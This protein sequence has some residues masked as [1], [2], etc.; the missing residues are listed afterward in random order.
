[1]TLEQ[2]TIRNV[3][4]SWAITYQGLTHRTLAF[5]VPVDVL[6][7]Y[8]SQVDAGV[9]LSHPEYNTSEF[10]SALTQAINYHT[11]EDEDVDDTTDSLRK[12]NSHHRE[13]DDRRESELR[14]QIASLEDEI[15][16]GT[17]D[18]EEERFSND[19][20]DE[21]PGEEKTPDDT[22]SNEPA[23]AGSAAESPEERDPAYANDPD[24][25]DEHS[26]LPPAIQTTEGD[27]LVV[28]D[29]DYELDTDEEKNPTDVI[30]GY[31]DEDNDEEE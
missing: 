11:S 15:Q 29:E 25:A 2:N 14:G 21:A 13:I 6:H 27:N 20:E 30:P 26:I 7:S 31:N 16:Q 18:N 17:G 3:N 10:K 28:E 1:M 8:K 24:N 9:E 5:H 4:K 12:L 19:E 22:V 23:P